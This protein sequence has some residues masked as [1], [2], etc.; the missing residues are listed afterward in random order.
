MTEAHARRPLR[1]RDW[2]GYLVL[3]VA[4]GTTFWRYDSDSRSS[5]PDD[6][7]R[8]EERWVQEVE[9]TAR[10]TGPLAIKPTG[11]FRDLIADEELG[12]IVALE[13]PFWTKANIGIMLHSLRLWG[14]AATFERKW[15]V[16]DGPRIERYQCPEQLRILLD[17]S[18]LLKTFSS[19]LDTP[20]LLSEGELGVSV[21]TNLDADITSKQGQAH[22]DK[23]LQVLAE[24]GVPSTREVT[25]LS[26]GTK[27]PGSRYTVDDIL[28]EALWCYSPFQE[29]D[30]T[31]SA[32]SRW[33]RPPASWT[34]RFGEHHTLDELV[35]RLLDRKHGTGACF[36]AHEFY[37]LAS[38]LR[39]NQVE[40]LVSGPTSAKAGER[41]REVSGILARSQKEDGSWSVDWSG[42]F[43]HPTSGWP[44]Y[45]DE[46]PNPEVLV[47]GHHLE[48]IAMAPPAVCPPRHVVKKAVDYLKRTMTSMTRPFFVRPEFYQPSTHAARALCLIR[49]V[50]AQEI[51]A[52]FPATPPGVVEVRD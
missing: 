7:P 42:P 48:W 52:R 5:T 14:A 4:V 46:S 45:L 24:I 30:F 39:A 35:N 47:T 13:E 21:L 44:A 33:L 49:G 2:L 27:R 32:F 17:R 25:I 41:L 3:L 31:V 37:A 22:P 19:H 20:A 1:I 8:P 12:P 43:V 6:A 18:A 16:V 38:I 15:Q 28:I 26:T 50:S 9:R 40:P 36:G 23:L 29:P 51:H 10:R 34:N 11:T